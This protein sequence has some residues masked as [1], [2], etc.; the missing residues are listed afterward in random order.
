MAPPYPS[1]AALKVSL[2]YFLSARAVVVEKKSR[3]ESVEDQGATTTII[4][5]TWL[6]PLPLLIPNALPAAF[7]LSVVPMPFLGLSTHRSRSGSTSCF[8]AAGLAYLP[9]WIL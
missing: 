4:K 1:L 8:F 7:L 9:Y 5:E 3:R 6:Q 2:D